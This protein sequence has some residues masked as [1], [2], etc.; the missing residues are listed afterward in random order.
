MLLVIHVSRSVLSYIVFIISST[1]FIYISKAVHDLADSATD[2]ISKCDSE[3]NDV[4]AS[5]SFFFRSPYLIVPI[6]S[7]A[8]RLPF[9]F[10]IQATSTISTLTLGCR[11]NANIFFIHW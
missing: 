9:L 4:A 8:I 1:G 2:W 11:C 3:K 7:F 5:D 6:L 10:A